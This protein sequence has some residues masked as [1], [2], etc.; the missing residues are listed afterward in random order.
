MIEEVAARFAANV[1]SDD[2]VRDTLITTG[3]AV[4]SDVKDAHLADFEGV[5]IRSFDDMRREVKHAS[6][7]SWYPT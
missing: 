3:P 7:H 4:V 2:L 1:R 6:M 5:V